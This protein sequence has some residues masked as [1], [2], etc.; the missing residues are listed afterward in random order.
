M[1]CDPDDGCDVLGGLREND[2]IRLRL[3][4]AAV[5]FVEP[6]VFWTK[7]IS[8]GADDVL[9]GVNGCVGDHDLQQRLDEPYQLGIGPGDR[10][11]VALRQSRVL[12]HHFAVAIDDVALGNLIGSVAVAQILPADRAPSGTPRRSASRNSGTTAVPV[13]ADA[14]HDDAR[15][16]LNVLANSLS[17]GASSTQGAHQ[18]AQKFSTRTLPP[19]SARRNLIAGGSG[20]GEVREPCHRPR[21]CAP[22]WTTQPRMPSATR[23]ARDGIFNG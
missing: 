15:S 17:E 14:Q 4:D 5:I 11:A 16:S 2:Q 7:E 9:D 12:T 21:R 23:S 20:D 13:D 8:A 3:V 1:I 10:L 18:L 19:K 6:E 22:A